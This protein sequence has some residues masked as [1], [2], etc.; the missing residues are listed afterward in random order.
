MAS[1]AGRERRKATDEPAMDKMCAAATK[2]PNWDKEAYEKLKKSSPSNLKNSKDYAEFLI[3]Q[4][5]R[6]KPY[7]RGDD[8]GV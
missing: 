2:Y 8:V 7:R 6:P 1:A 5:Q 4:N 3:L